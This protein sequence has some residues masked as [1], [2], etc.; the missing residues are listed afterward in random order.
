MLKPGFEILFADGIRRLKRVRKCNRRHQ[1]TGHV[2]GEWRGTSGMDSQQHCDDKCAQTKRARHSPMVPHH[3]QNHPSSRDSF[4]WRYRHGTPWKSETREDVHC[5]L[6]ESIIS[7]GHLLFAT[8]GALKPAKCFYH[9]ISFS[10]KPD[11][12]W[13][14]DANKSSHVL[15]F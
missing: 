9:I 3:Q 7:W 1:N 12:S 10:W 15:E 11:S 2:S 6:Q 8:G 14:Y 4:C 13:K 5:A